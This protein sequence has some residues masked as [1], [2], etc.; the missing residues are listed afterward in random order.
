MNR[1]RAIGTAVIA[2][3]LVFGP[4]GVGLAQKAS[5]RPKL[6]S[7]EKP[8]RLD[9]D[10][11][12][13]P[14]PKAYETGYLYDFANNTFFRPVKKVFNVQQHVRTIAGSAP[15]SLNVNTLDE[16]PDSSWFTN[17]NGRRRMSIE[18]IKRGPNTT[19]GPAPG[20]LTVTRGK[21]NGV[22]PG[23]QVRDERGD[24]YLLKFDPPD[25]PELS[26]AAEAI[27]TRLFY[28][29]GYNVPEN[30]VFYFRR[31]Q[32]VPHSEAKFKDRLGNV[33]AFTN[34]DIDNILKLAAKQPDGT[35]RCLAS[36]FVPGSKIN[37]RFKR[38]K[39]GD[40]S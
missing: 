38:V 40:G 16:V 33:R 15:E 31:E 1:Q 21:S 25:Y 9:F 19:D 39:E 36:K 22:T 13:I 11:K 27:S 29:I 17:R 28:A 7:K 23:F 20:K 14:Q 35:Y 26:S 5:S 37:A 32:L 24:S 2:F 34:A 30:N 3:S 10:M 18:E 6:Y 4:V 8:V 12:T